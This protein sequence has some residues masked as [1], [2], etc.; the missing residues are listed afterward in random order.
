VDIDRRT[1]AVPDAAVHY[2]FGC[3]LETLLASPG[4]AWF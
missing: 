1:I 4:R 2:A 3:G